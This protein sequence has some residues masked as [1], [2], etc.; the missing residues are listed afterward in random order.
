[1]TDDALVAAAADVAKAA[2]EGHPQSPAVVSL[3]QA[4]AATRDEARRHELAR[5]A[6][7]RA[8]ELT[9]VGL[10]LLR[11]AIFALAI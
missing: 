6:A 10:Q 3:L 4:L 11:V 5:R 9:A 1:M 8:G 7:E 2:S